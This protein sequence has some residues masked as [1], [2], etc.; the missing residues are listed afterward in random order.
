ML[1]FWSFVN[2]TLTFCPDLYIFFKNSFL[3]K[4]VNQCLLIIFR[5]KMPQDVPVP[6]PIFKQIKFW[7]RKP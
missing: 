3:H 5:I 1:Y 6:V 4:V 2:I 7:K